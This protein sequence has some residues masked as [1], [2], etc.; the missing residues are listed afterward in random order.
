MERTFL[1]IT[2]IPTYIL[3]HLALQHLQ[4]LVI[5]HKFSLCTGSDKQVLKI[6]C[7]MRLPNELSQ[8]LAITFRHYRE[9]ES[10]MGYDTEAEGLASG[11]RQT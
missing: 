7:D 2:C 3:T 5:V 8:K 10:R 4:I 1:I 6:I 9:D 11:S